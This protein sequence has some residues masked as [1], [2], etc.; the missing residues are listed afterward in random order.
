MVMRWIKQLE[1]RLRA[2]AADSDT[3]LTRGQRFL[4][5]C[6][7]LGRHARKELRDD[8]A[9]T[10]AAALT[11]R[12]IF[13]LVPMV[14]MALI[15][16]RAF[17]GFEDTQQSLTDDVYDML[18]IEEVDTEA[19]LAKLIEQAE[20]LE[21]AKLEAAAT[22][23]PAPA[24]IPDLDPKNPTPPPAKPA[25]PNEAQANAPNSKASWWGKP[26]KQVAS[27]DPADAD[28]LADPEL[29]AKRAQLIANAEMRE[30]IDDLLQGLAKAATS[31]KIGGIGII[32]MLL[33]IW[34]AI[35]LIVTVEKTF[36]VV[37]N[38]PQGRRWHIRIPIY[39]AII[40][41]G[42]VLIWGSYYLSNQ[43]VE[44]TQDLPVLTWLVGLFKQTTAVLVTWILFV[45]LFKLMPN[46]EVG[47]RPAMVGA[48]VSALAWELLKFGLRWFIES[49]VISPTHARLY[50]SLALI[51][52]LLF[53]VYLT[54]LIVLA[55]L[56]VTYILQTLPG[57]R[58]G[59]F[60]IEQGRPAPIARD[61]WLV[62]PVMSAVA[63]AF[64]R[65]K[66]I[67]VDEI[68]REVKASAPA[69]DKL[70][71]E[72][73]NR[74]LLHKLID[75]DDQSALALAMP[76]GKIRIADLIATA[77]DQAGNA[78][79][80]GHDLLMQ[81]AKAQDAALADV[82]LDGSKHGAVS[83]GSDSGE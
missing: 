16:F 21:K 26:F 2:T 11:Y 5:F 42:P 78:K 81:L 6:L 66:T 45:L 57:N 3:S 58:V 70:V 83:K 1:Q 19:E 54:W 68:A 46:T 48:L 32:G 40:T 72:L 59:R 65:G 61:P 39:W 47:I 43:I 13:G 36:N 50:G 76:P 60:E 15:V 44:V 71:N 14:V 41:L 64:E 18:G 27:V 75:E 80:P 82:T 10:M 56:E 62:I 7:D 67:G 24:R 17:G 69:V 52:I 49:A 9:P 31:I 79:L 35:G 8:S 30:R 12:T 33:L 51:P 37:F 34:A 74:G 29:E 77:P 22:K 25:P 4:W 73:V 28:K 63:Q 38:A 53:W 55:G 23:Q 20:A